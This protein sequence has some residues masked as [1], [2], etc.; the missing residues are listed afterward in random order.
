MKLLC[1]VIL[2]INKMED[3][4]YLT[5]SYIDTYDSKV[6]EVNILSSKLFSKDKYHHNVNKIIRWYNK[7]TVKKNANLNE[8]YDKDFW[9]KYYRKFYDSEYLLTYPELM[10][11]KLNRNDLKNLIDNTLP[12]ENR[13]RYDV[14]KFLKNEIIHIED[15]IYTGW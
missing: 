11:R 2:L 10:A 14:I 1:I 8:R 5:L 4:M 15:I 7:Y 12:T 9:I 3:I 6:N 13:S